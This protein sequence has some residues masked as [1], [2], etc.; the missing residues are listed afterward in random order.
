MKNEKRFIDAKA[1]A[2][3]L[4][5]IAEQDEMLIFHRDEI[6]DEIYHAPT[7]DAVEVVRCKDCKHFVSPQGWPCC[8]E[9][10]GLGFPNPSGDDFCSYGERREGK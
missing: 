3:M 6:I 10:L 2:E 8:D 9:F 5:K 7:V 1:L 4:E